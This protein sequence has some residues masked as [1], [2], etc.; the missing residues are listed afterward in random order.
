MNHGHHQPDRRASCRTPHAGRVWWLGEGQENFRAA[1]TT[2]RSTGG[3]AFVT[4]AGIPVLAGQTL[5]LSRVHPRRHPAA[6]ETLRVCRVE[7]YGGSLD[8]VA[9]ARPA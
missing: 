1:W 4:A 7:P 9:C 8:L 2:D 3:L 6:C 5:F